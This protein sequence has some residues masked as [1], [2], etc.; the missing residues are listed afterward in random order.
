M[1]LI[2]LGALQPSLKNG[3]V[4]DM[5]LPI[6][7]LREIVFHFL[8]SNDFE[9]LDEDVVPFLMRHHQVTKKSLFQAQEIVKELKKHRTELDGAIQLH[10]KEYELDRIP[11]VERNVLR[12]GI[13]EIMYSKQTPPKVAISEALRLARKFA[14]AES[15]QY[16]NAVLDSVYQALRAPEV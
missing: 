15:A 8:Y 1:Y 2:F 6:Q 9:A 14:T 11:R 5:P 12:L 10:S 4:V 7:K 13:F 16:I 3:I